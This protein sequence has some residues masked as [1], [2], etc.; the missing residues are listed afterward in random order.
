MYKV[1]PQ[2]TKNR[3]AELYRCGMA[4]DDVVKQTGVS[5]NTVKKYTRDVFPGHWPKPAAGAEAPAETLKEK[6]AEI[7]APDEPRW[8]VPPGVQVI[9]KETVI[10]RYGRYEIEN[11]TVT[12]EIQQVLTGEDSVKE[13]MDE[14]RYLYLTVRSHHGV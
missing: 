1:I 2:D 11:D 12:I 3:I 13:L 6:L 14:I 7:N 10:G 8:S 4:V 9:R 5:R